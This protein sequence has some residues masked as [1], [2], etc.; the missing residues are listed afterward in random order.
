M[1]QLKNILSGPGSFGL[2]VV[3][4]L[5][6]GAPV[7]AQGLHA[8]TVAKGLAHPWAVAFLPDGRING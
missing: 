4:S 5:A 2:G 6:L 7:M 3:M 1:I 8:E